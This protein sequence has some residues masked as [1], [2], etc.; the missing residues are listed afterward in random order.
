[1]SLIVLYFEYVSSSELTFIKYL[2]VPGTMLSSLH[3]LTY[4]ILATLYDPVR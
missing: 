3:M 2:F 1:M 4:L